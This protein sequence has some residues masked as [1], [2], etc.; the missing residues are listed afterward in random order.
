MPLKTLMHKKNMLK[1]I[2]NELKGASIAKLKL[3]MGIDT[4][5]DILK[6]V[7]ELEGVD[8][9]KPELDMGTDA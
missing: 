2:H 9:A 3:D 6:G 7:L 4:R 5:K 1:G 8:V